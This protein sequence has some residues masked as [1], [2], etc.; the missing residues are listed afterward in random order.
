MSRTSLL[1]GPKTSIGNR[2]L[3]V[4][5]NEDLVVFFTWQ[6][7]SLLYNTF[8]VQQYEDRYYLVTEKN[9]ALKNSRFIRAI[10]AMEIS[11]GHSA[12]HSL[13]LE[14]LPKHSASILRTMARA[15]RAASGRPWGN[16]ASWEIFAP[17]NSM[18]DAL[19]QAAT[20]A[21]QPIQAAASMAFSAIS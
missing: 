8:V 4:F 18:A 12:S 20:H 9:P 10:L 19:G 5:D 15:R 6:T 7:A 3:F 14:Q 16:S 17:T 21:P 13:S 2:L 11:L 1:K